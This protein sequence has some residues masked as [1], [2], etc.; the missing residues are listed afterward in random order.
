MTPRM[1]EFSKMHG[2]GN[3]F[4]V[5]DH[6]DN[7]L[8]SILPD[9]IRNLCD[10]HFGVGA[11]GALL[12]ETSDKP[13]QANYRMRFYNQD[14]SEADMCGN[15][16]R[17]AAQYSFRRGIA[18]KAHAFATKSGVYRAEVHTNRLVSLFLPPV[19]QFC[20]NQEIVVDGDRI[21]L[22][23]LDT[24]VPHA[25]IF[26]PNLLDFSDFFS[27]SIV[28]LKK[29]GR[30]V[31]FHPEFEPA[32]INV[33]LV[34]Q[35]R[36]GLDGQSIFPIRTYERGVEDETLACGTGIVAASLALHAVRDVPSPI[37]FTT[38]GRSSLQT[39]FLLDKNVYRKIELTGP[40]KM[41]F[42]GKLDLK[43]ISLC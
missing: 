39:R 9:I 20:M 23:V 14:G 37:Q 19:A 2:A 41:V 28:D 3:D 5:I 35:P 42:Q 24:G 21:K 38:T 18:G 43:G 8:E 15:A 22:H 29:I 25:V 40:T 31:R 17:C 34:G 30:G 7:R 11:D 26:Y 10:R 13:D 4:I 1:L 27:N 16:G 32:G 12:I 6:R 36:Q 33:D